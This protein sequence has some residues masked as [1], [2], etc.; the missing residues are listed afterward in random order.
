MKSA[1]VKR[2]FRVLFPHQNPEEIKKKYH[3]PATLDLEIKLTPDGWFV[4]TSPELPGLI[5]QARSKDDL[6]EMINDAILTYFD[7]PKREADIV[8][9]QFTLGGETI[10]Y[11]GELATK[12]A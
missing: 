3:L 4:A 5:T 9:N 7:V 12:M 2:A 8:Y 6:L 10:Q 1:F 11:Q